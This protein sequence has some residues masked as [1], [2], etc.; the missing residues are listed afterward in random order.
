[1]GDMPES[2]TVTWSN[3]PDSGDSSY[4]VKTV[5]LSFVK[6]DDGSFELTNKLQAGLE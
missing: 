4:A 1:M 2:M 5:T 6:Q 3:Q